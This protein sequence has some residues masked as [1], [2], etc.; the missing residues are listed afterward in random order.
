MASLDDEDE[1]VRWVAAEALI[2]LKCQCLKPLLTTLTERSY[3][4]WRLRGAHHV[5]HSLVKNNYYPRLIPLFE[6]FE[7]PE[8]ELAV[9][10]AASA[11]MRELSL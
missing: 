10:L 8:P 4:F 1:G 6:A 7:H 11:I 3:A 2:A 9:P 5:C